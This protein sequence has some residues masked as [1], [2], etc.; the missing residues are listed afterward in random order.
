MQNETN[1][2]A[3]IKKTGLEVFIREDVKPHSSN[4]GMVCVSK[5][6]NT[7]VFSVEKE[8]LEIIK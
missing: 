1:M 4:Y 6:L 2:K 5:G 7:A 8:D 3:T